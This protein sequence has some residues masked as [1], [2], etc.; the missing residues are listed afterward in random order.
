M[1]KIWGRD[2]SVNVEKVLWACEEMK[3]AYQRVDAGGQFGIVD[4][5]DYRALNPNGLVPTVEVDGLVLWESNA[6]VRYLAAKHSPGTLWPNDLAIR[7]E[8]DRWMD[9][10]NSTFWPGF[11]P[12][13]WNLVRTPP[14]QRDAQE[15]EAS[16]ARSAEI[17]GFLDAHLS[18]RTYIAGDTFTVG[19]IP[20]GCAIWRWMSLPIERA[21]YPALQRWFDTL[22]NRQPYQ[23][24][25]MKPLT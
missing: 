6:I 5:P 17:L 10:M 13:F 15:I 21:E 4:E 1:L 24:V 12:L 7:V 16:L 8:G 3:I 23:K 25:V 14:D 11:R 2:N 19:D 9:W 18:N 22:C 20:M